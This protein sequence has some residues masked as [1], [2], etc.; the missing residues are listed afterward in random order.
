M[1][2]EIRLFG[3]W[4]ILPRAQNLKPKFE[5]QTLLAQNSPAV[6]LELI[7]FGANLDLCWN[8]PASTL[9]LLPFGSKSYLPWDLKFLEITSRGFLSAFSDTLE[10][11]PF[12]AN[13]DIRWNFPA[14]TSELI[15]FGA[16]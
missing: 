9:E 2:R 14:G 5:F 1:Q 12:G 11:I 13:S 10:L 15:P 7:H 8:C 16:N 3:Y 6:T 4:Y